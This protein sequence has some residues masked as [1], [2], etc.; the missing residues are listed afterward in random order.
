[1]KYLKFINI[2]FFDGEPTNDDGAA[3]DNPAQN[4]A[5]GEGDPTGTNADLPIS[6]K[7]PQTK[8]EP[9]DEYAEFNIKSPLLKAGRSDDTDDSDDDN[10]PEPNR[11][12]KEPPAQQQPPVAPDPAKPYRTLKYRGQ[13]VPVMT[14]DDLMGLASQG[15][16][17]TQKTQRIAPYKALVDRLERDPILMQQVR[18]LL[19]G[20]PQ[21]LIP[22]I[23]PKPDNASPAKKA[24]PEPEQQDDET[25]DEY[26]ERREQW[27]NGKGTDSQQN[28]Q[29]VP[30][31]R[32][33]IAS[34]VEQVLL[35]R[36][37]QERVTTIAKVTLEDPEH[38]SVLQR[39][40]GLPESLR[41]A[42]EQD[43]V[44]YQIIYDQVRKDMG[45]GEYFLPFHQA[46][47]RNSNPVSQP[48][49]PSAQA[50]TPM[51]IKGT[52]STKA[53]F[54]ENGKGGTPT[55]GK[56]K[57]G[58]D[59]WGMPHEEFIKMRDGVADMDNKR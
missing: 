19:E 8:P 11:D 17:Y 32:E 5:S 35:E 37:R 54:T 3:S 45:K 41:T 14:E 59:I 2:K 22:Q 31:T 30:L 43:D 34:E 27:K 7:T 23:Q 48:Q 57:P 42:M 39:I 40:G 49:V 51:S 21:A 52:P 15:I 53:P 25:W 12:A 46:A 26:L 56:S 24:G 6:D 16:D 58:I 9:Y 1:M 4:P 29:E 28:A 20:G 50:A 10:N 44:A 36:Q 18:T 38:L 55:V 33:S 47:G 13:E